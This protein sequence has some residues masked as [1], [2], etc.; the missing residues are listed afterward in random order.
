MQH[1]FHK[2]LSDN[3]FK[4][5]NSV[6]ETHHH[7]VPNLSSVE[8]L[9]ESAKKRNLFVNQNTLLA[10]IFIHVCLLFCGSQYFF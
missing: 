6:N 8:S 10:C 5:E 9:K 4:N 3:S 2:P 1:W 7:V